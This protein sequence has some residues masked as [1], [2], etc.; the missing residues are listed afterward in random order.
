MIFIFAYDKIRD[1]KGWVYLQFSQGYHLPNLSV[2]ESE[3]DRLLDKFI[4]TSFDF[5][6]LLKHVT[7]L[8]SSLNVN[9]IYLSNGKKL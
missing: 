5:C 3:I 9:T 4:A 7:I 6:S 2:V 8:A 1:L